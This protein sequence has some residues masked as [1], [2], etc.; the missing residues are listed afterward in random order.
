MNSGANLFYRLRKKKSAD[1]SALF[2]SKAV[3][4]SDRTLSCAGMLKEIIT[5]CFNCII[6]SQIVII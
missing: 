5:V 3:W 4:I 6:K 1:K 2:H